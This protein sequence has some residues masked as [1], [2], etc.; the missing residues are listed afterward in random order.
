M[1]VHHHPEVEKKGFKEYLLEGLMIFLAVT[2]GFIAETIR[3]S[4]SE[5]ERAKSYASS[6]LKDLEADSVQLKS[7]R[8]Y[9][10]YCANK[11]D[12]FMNILEVAE[13]KNIPSGKLYWYGLFGAGHRYFIPDDATF[14]Q[15]KS[16]GSLR[17]F[18]KTVANDVAKYD[19]LCRYL[20][21]QE[22][23]NQGIYTEA[24]KMR[25][26]FFEF[27]YL[28]IANTIY[29]S[30]RISFN[31]KK[32][33]SFTRSSPPLLSTDKVLFNQYVELA[34]SRFMHVNV[35]IADSLLKQGS[36]LIN[37]LHKTYGT[38]ND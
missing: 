19:R 30:N 7:Y 27:R 11:V 37:E 21:S 23:V 33:D 17:Y 20:L 26:Q 28:N 1:E 4:I 13:P 38:E 22:Q 3:E 2:L 5:H 31:Q 16:S 34:R 18:D 35:A 36:V 6:M 8:E 10:D 9:F 14:Q 29:Q 32:I 24:R 15:M 12:T 25:S